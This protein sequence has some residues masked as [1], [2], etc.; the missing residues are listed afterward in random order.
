LRPRTLTLL[1]LAVAAVVALVV[2]STAL[3]GGSCSEDDLGLAEHVDHY[4]GAELEFF[5]DPEGS[6]CAA[7]FEVSATADD[8]LGH[9]ER[10]L[11]AG[12]WDVS[13]QDVRTEGLP[14]EDVVVRD[15][16]ARRG[17]AEFTIALESVSGQTSFGIRV[18][19]G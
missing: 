2:V 14:D 17:D 1:G 8:V 18:D 4:G 9:Y 12:G 7:R 19:A 11:E 6:G 15:L 10:E 5:D 13:I 16:I 3:I